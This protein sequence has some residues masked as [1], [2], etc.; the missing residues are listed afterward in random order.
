MTRSLGSERMGLS[1]AV[2]LAISLGL[3][4][5]SSTPAQAQTAAHWNFCEGAGNLLHD[6]S[7]NQNHG[8][9]LGPDW[10]CD[11]E[12]WSLRFDGISDDQVAVADAPS[13]RIACGTIEIIFRTSGGFHAGDPG[14]QLLDKELGGI[15]EG[16]LEIYF[17]STTGQLTVQAEGGGGRHYARSDA[18]SWDDG[19]HHMAYT[20]GDHGMELFV[21]GVAQIDASPFPASLEENDRPLTMGF[22]PSQGTAALDGWIYA[23]RISDAVLAPGEFLTLADCCCCGGSPAAARTWGGVKSAYR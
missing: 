3:L 1:C 7:G 13:L 2:V 8:D 20:F 6:V 4:V 12:L 21:D 15:Y 5:A 11:H 14:E 10:D 19:I 18:T 16:D 17:A 9:I 22:N 23:V